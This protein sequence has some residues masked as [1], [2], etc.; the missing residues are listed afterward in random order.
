MV[1]IAWVQG[2][3]FRGV[4]GHGLILHQE[5]KELGLRPTVCVVVEPEEE[6][7]VRFLHEGCRC[8]CKWH[9]IVDDCAQ[10]QLQRP[11]ASNLLTRVCNVFNSRQVCVRRQRSDVISVKCMQ[12]RFNGLQRVLPEVSEADLRCSWYLL[13]VATMVIS[14]L[15][16]FSSLQSAQ[17]LSLLF[18]QKDVGQQREKFTAHSTL[19]ALRPRRRAAT[20][21]SSSRSV[22]CRMPGEVGGFSKYHR[23]GWATYR[24]VGCK[25]S[26]VLRSADWKIWSTALAHPTGLSTCGE[27]FSG[28]SFGRFFY[29]AANRDILTHS[30]SSCLGWQTAILVHP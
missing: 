16:M 6:D 26:A 10:S 4:I 7:E 5:D 15:R 2:S 25:D 9:T 3:G 24:I 30:S 1:W 18:G 22:L 14:L 28:F 12:S 29:G 11:C 17:N 19:R 20:G 21:I 27:H 8:C 13:V 23:E